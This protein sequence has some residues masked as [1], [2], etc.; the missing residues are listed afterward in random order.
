MPTHTSPDEQALPSAERSG[1]DK[2]ALDVYRQAVEHVSVAASITDVNANILY[3]NPAFERLTGYDQAEVRGHNES[4]LSDKATPVEVYRDLWKTISSGEVWKGRLVNRRKNGTP[5]LA[6]LTVVPVLDE[7]GKVRHFLGLHHD[8]TDQHQLERRVENQDALLSSIIEAA[9]VLIALVNTD[10]EVIFSNP[11]YKM[12]RRNLHGE[13]VAAYFLDAFT[14]SLGI[15]L[16]DMCD[17]GFDFSVV[18]VRV[19]LRDDETRWFACSASKVQEHD[20]SAA[21]YFTKDGRSGLLLVASDITLQR[22]R[23]EEARTNAVRA[24]MAEQQMMQGMREVISGAIFQMQGPL[25]VMSAAAQM[26]ERQGENGN[27]AP[28]KA[29]IHEMLNAGNAALERLKAAMPRTAD[30]PVG[31]VNINELVREVLDVSIEGLLRQGIFVDWRPAQ[32]LPNVPGRPNALR[33]MI[34]YLVD[35][36]ILAIKDGGSGREVVITTSATTD[37]DVK[38]EVRDFGPGLAGDL[39]LKIYEPF[40]TAWKKTR[41]RPGMGLVLARQIVTDQGGSLEIENVMSGGCKAEVV[42][43]AARLGHDRDF[44]QEG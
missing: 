43:A 16:Q 18:E 40:F 5:Y 27:D 9:P 33:S 21:G 26:L 2:V 1:A 22:R 35:N 32:I 15:S 11:A 3:A 25:N 4:L 8:V 14:Q 34:K 28:L 38:L 6:D 17:K 30:E 20:L 23:Y 7:V 24:L 44:E 36:A 12:L 39:R 37:G 31:P 29:P 42:L 13:N 10:G 19:D 41:S